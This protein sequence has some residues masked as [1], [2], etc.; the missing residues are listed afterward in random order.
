MEKK[1]TN[2]LATRQ[3]KFIEQLEAALMRIDNK[4]YGICRSQNIYLY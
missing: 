3:K 4:T 2:Q 1:Q